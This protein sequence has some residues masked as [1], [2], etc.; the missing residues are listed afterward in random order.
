MRRGR[1]ALIPLV[2]GPLLGLAVTAPAAAGTTPIKNLPGLPG[3]SRLHS[4]HTIPAKSPSARAGFVLWDTSGIN[5]STTYNTA[6]GVVSVTPTSTGLY[7]VEFGQLHIT[8]GD[9]QISALSGTCTIIQWF[10]TTP[11]LFVDVACYNAA[12]VLTNE[13]Y[14]VTVT[15]PNRAPSGVLDYAWTYRSSGPLQGIYQYNSSGRKNSIKHTGVGQ[16]LVTMPGPPV[17]GANTGTVKVS[18]YGLGAGNCQLAGWRG[19]RAGQQISVDCFSAAGTR[20]NREFTVVYARGNN[21]IGENGKVDANAFANGSADLYQPRTQFDSNR[22]ARVTVI[23]L[24]RGLY[25]VVF[26][27]S[28][29]TAGPGGIGAMLISAAGPAY[30]ECAYILTPTHTTF[31][32]VECASV[33]GA[34]NAPFIVQWVINEPSH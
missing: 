10:F 6:G 12:G 14:F 30:R 22:H 15:Q 29:P 20:Q 32:L 28:H 31:A 13:P 11:N 1:L 19:T 24:D 25:E 2:V 23:H 26:V 18:A 33:H 7:A 17:R 8:G 16:Y 4:V 9:V 21:V 27:G 34:V 3:S 5:P